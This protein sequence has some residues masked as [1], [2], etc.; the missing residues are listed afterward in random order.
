MSEAVMLTG[1]G[2]TFFH[3]TSQMSAIKLEGKGLRFKRSVLAHCKR[4]Y[5]L[6]GNREQV[7]AQMQVMKDELIKRREQ[8]LA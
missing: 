4:Y 5:K 8:G 2:V 1:E 3:V 7:L 6:K